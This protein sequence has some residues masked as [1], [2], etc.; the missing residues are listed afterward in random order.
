M[1]LGLRQDFLQRSNIGGSI[2]SPHMGFARYFLVIISC[3]LTT[4]CAYGNDYYRWGNPKDMNLVDG[5]SR[6]EAIN[7]AKRFLVENSLDNNCTMIFPRVR[8]SIDKT[9]WV[10]HFFPNIRYLL[11]VPFGYIVEVHKINGSIRLYGWAK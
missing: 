5:V 9:H 4:A 11:T 7:V 3:L 8:E 6:D 10:V 2:G 1:G